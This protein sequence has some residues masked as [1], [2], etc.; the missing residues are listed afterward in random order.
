MAACDLPVR[1]IPS[2]IRF[3]LRV[4]KITNINIIAE[5]NKFCWKRKYANFHCIRS[6]LTKRNKK[7]LKGI[8]ENQM[9]YAYPS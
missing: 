5:E 2:K 3:K 9:P 4:Q 1:Y 8:N 6:T 7:N